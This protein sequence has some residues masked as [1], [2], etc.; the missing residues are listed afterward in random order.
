MP[1]KN[2]CGAKKINVEHGDGV[3]ADS[4]QRLAE[5]RFNV[6]VSRLAEMTAHCPEQ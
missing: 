6:A 5:I 1:K 3:D 2:H 4:P